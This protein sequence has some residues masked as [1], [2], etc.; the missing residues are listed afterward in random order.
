MA[1][2]CLIK[3]IITGQIVGYEMLTPEQIDR[4]NNEGSYKASRFYDEE[5]CKKVIDNL[6]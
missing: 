6:K 5:T 4:I 3:D 2:A 1:R